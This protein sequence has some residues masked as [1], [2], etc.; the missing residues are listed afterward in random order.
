M[1]SRSG[2]IGP[3][4]GG[5]GGTGGHVLLTTSPHLSDLSTVPK[6]LIGGQGSNAAGGWKH[7][8]RGNDLVVQVPIG[9][10]IR[11]IR[12]EGEEERWERD[13]AA[14]GIG[15]GLSD[16]EER[17]RRQRE[18]WYIKH[19]G[20]EVSDD[21][22]TLANGILKR[23]GF[24]APSPTFD[25][26]PPLDLDLAQPLDKP[27]LLSRGGKGGL[28]NPHFH[29]PSTAAGGSKPARLASRGVQPPTLTFELELKL[30]AD[31]GLVGFPNAGKST[32]LRAL[33]GR[34]AEVAG[35]SFTTLNPQVGVVRVWDDGSWGTGTG[36]EAIS[37]SSQ[38]KA[39]DGNG[40][41]EMETNDFQGTIIE[42]SEIER[43]RE[44]ALISSGEYIPPPPRHSSL[45]ASKRKVERIR[46]T[47]SDNPGLLPQASA[48]V[49]LGHTFLR[50]LERCRLHVYVLDLGRD[51]PAADLKVLREE[52]EAW[53][54]GLSMR[55]AVVV[56]NKGDDVDEDVGRGR[57]EGVKDAVGEEGLGWEVVTVSAKF[58]LGLG[59]L[60][61][62]LG[63]KM[64]AKR[65]EEGSA[66]Q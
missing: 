10:I 15:N 14:L 49:G 63:G 20:G 41:A 12:R 16:K 62:L 65:V 55:D 1:G 21:D 48:N 33:T 36:S 39:L 57:V 60:V 6:R 11:E 28:G 24:F 13:L 31:V 18:R 56:L 45:D 64:E 3:P 47:I 38:S 66:E 50:H 43:A 4:S 27:L 7:G 54:P 42:E 29:I 51:D 30:L 8:K 23:E 22:F 2:G 52:M 35:Y 17:R 40:S 61:D 53:L 9:T 25:E 44:A 32:I 34:K 5:D 59:R 37:A 19:P 26:L 46:F 58:G